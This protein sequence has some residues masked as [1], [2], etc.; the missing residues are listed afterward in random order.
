LNLPIDKFQAL[1]ERLGYPINALA[2][3]IDAL[4][5]N[6]DTETATDCC[7]AIVTSAQSAFG[8]SARRVLDDWNVCSSEDVGAILF[9]ALDANLISRE[10]GLDH[11]AFKKSSGLWELD[12]HSGSSANE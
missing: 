3:V 1:S 9:A 2:F 10:K 12:S 4:L 7:S 11:S 8:A 6:P 5:L